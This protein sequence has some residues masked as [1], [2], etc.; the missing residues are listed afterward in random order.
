[1]K[2]KSIDGSVIETHG[3]IETL[4]CDTGVQIPYH[5]QL[6]SNQVDVVGDGILGRDFFKHTQAEICY[7]SGTLTFCYNR[8]NVV[9]PLRDCNMQDE[10]QDSETLRL[11]PRYE[12]LVKLQV[13][14]GTTVTEGLVENQE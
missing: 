9:K 6:V 3:S 4:I 2:I 14:E 8:T 5:F 10:L 11:N 12:T 1:M 7:A 13:G